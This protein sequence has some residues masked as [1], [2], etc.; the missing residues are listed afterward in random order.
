MLPN[1]IWTEAGA[2][3]AIYRIANYIYID[4]GE[5]ERARKTQLP[6]EGNILI[7][8]LST[9]SDGWGGRNGIELK[10]SF[11]IVRPWADLSNA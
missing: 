10:F 2:T 3:I 7:I 4:D 6:T 1:I 8:S 5:R 9:I 11:S